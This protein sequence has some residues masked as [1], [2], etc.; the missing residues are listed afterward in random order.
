MPAAQSA[1]TLA[2]AARHPHE[3]RHA[4]SGAGALDRWRGYWDSGSLSPAPELNLELSQPRS[5]TPQTV[6]TKPDA[7]A[8]D[9][10]LRLKLK[11]H[12]D[13][14]AASRADLDTPRVLT[15]SPLMPS[16]TR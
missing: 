7:S 15:G 10:Q 1:P 9:G 12:V 3:T 6:S 8:G 2:R 14:M 11:I 5:I 4:V 13:A 16:F